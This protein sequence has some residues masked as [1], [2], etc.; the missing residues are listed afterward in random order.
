VST[1]AA[2]RRFQFLREIAAGGFGVVY[3]AKIVQRDGFARLVAIKLL[4]SQWSENEEM[5][6][7]M[8]DEARLLGLLR[9]KNIVEV[10]DLTRIAG[11]VA[12]IMEYLEAIDLHG[13]LAGPVEEGAARATVPVR[14]SLEIC[15]AV[16]SALDAAYNRPPYGGD[17]PLR[18]IHRDIKPTNIMVDTNGTVKVLDFGIARADFAERE[19]RTREMAFGSLDYMPPERMFFEPDT[20]TSDIYSLGATLYE[21]LVG[22][23]LGRAKTS[24]EA[25]T[26]FLDQRWALVSERHALGEVAA[27]LRE[28]LTAMLAFEATER[29]S[30]ADA[31]VRLRA[32]ARRAEDE[33]VAEWAERAV[34]PLV[35]RMH[36]RE[37]PPS[38]ESL[39]GQVVEEDVVGGEPAAPAAPPPGPTLAATTTGTSETDGGDSTLRPRPSPTPPAVK[40]TPASPISIETPP[41]GA[42][43][44]LLVA[45]LA[46]G[47]LLFAS[48]TAALVLAIGSTTGV[49]GAPARAETP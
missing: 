49:T 26:A 36:Q 48:G 5:A 31:V 44:A 29:I 9:H 35:A 13:I 18:V 14:A 33:G 19:S 24:P 46:L 10:L 47:F 25:Q 34:P 43:V 30:S 28:L 6:S 37:A 40:R 12:V 22:E 21:M 32:L 17:Q 23:K 3:L 42:G 38:N 45:A 11:R 1:V 4:R 15:A 27:P 8:R 7:R 41:E 2:G 16:A 39:V 20:P